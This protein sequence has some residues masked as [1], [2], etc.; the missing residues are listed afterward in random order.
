MK[1]PGVSGRL[2]V[3][4]LSLVVVLLAGCS[5]TT[6]P[7][8][9]D[10]PTGKFD[11]PF[12]P[13]FQ[14]QG[15][16]AASRYDTIWVDVPTD[17]GLIVEVTSP[18][19]A[20][21]IVDQP[22]GLPAGSQRTIGS[23]KGRSLAVF[24]GPFAVGG[25]PVMLTVRPAA[26][27]SPGGADYTVKT[28]PVDLRPEHASGSI[29]IGT[30]VANEALGPGAD[31]DVFTVSTAIG[32]ADLIGFRLTVPSGSR[33]I[34]ATILNNG[35]PV[36]VL[37]TD[38]IQTEYL[39]YPVTVEAGTV[40]VQLTAMDV[41]RP[42]DTPPALP[43]QLEVF[44]VNPAPEQASPGLVY[45]VTITETLASAADVDDF[46]FEGHVDDWI[47][48]A[49]TPRKPVLYEDRLMI[50]VTRPDGSKYGFQTWTDGQI[51]YVP[52]LE[53]GPHSVRVRSDRITRTTYPYTL[54]LTRR[55][56]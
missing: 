12:A 43:Y 32:P 35:R 19:S 37:N 42:F 24:A 47:Y 29:E 31:S 10:P 8:V 53:N 21:L 49:P 6:G 7:Q 2:G 50:E 4:V 28:A 14:V 22:G 56:P 11:H 15:H 52:I 38:S 3:G 25:G 1:R 41:R 18:D 23:V 40:N 30:V 13:G 46:T 39:T 34:R 36:Q 17:V 54:M 16:V 55:A 45:D 5:E 44:R 27:T 48:F 33:S 51:L 9:P 20:F 26:F